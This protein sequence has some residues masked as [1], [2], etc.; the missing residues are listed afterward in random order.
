MT[1]LVVVALLMLWGYLAVRKLY[2][3]AF[4]VLH[5][6]ELGATTRNPGGYIYAFR[7]RNE[8]TNFIKIGRAKN[9]LQRL[10]SHRTA[11]PFGVEVLCVVGVKNDVKAERYL[12]TRFDANRISRNNEWFTCDRAMMRYLRN[13]RH[14]PLTKNVQSSLG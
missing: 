11:N 2:N 1:E 5:S 3:K 8:D 7:G 12:H 6:K 9:P 4:D 13:I 10:R 14:E